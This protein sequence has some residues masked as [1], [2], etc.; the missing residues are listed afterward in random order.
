M[1]E[2]QIFAEDI[3]QVFLAYLRSARQPA[4]LLPW[5][6][7]TEAIEMLPGLHKS[8]QDGELPKI[9]HGQPFREKAALLLDELRRP[10]RIAV[11]KLSDL[12]D[13]A[14]VD[15]ISIALERRSAVQ[16]LKD[17][18]RGTVAEGLF[19]DDLFVDGDVDLAEELRNYA[20]YEFST[21]RNMPAS[22]WWWVL[23]RGEI[24][25][26]APVRG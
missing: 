21:P 9:V 11:I 16:F 12:I 20:P 7:M 6:Y 22:H 23:A 24:S 14:S 17:D 3:A 18:F 2:T 1:T 4:K 15:E 26:D 10:V 8:T 5:E 25:P 13:E 19:D